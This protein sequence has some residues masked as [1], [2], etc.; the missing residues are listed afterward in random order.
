MSNAETADNII[1]RLW[2]IARMWFADAVDAFGPPAAIARL[3]RF[4][5]RAFARRL[6]ALETLAMKLLLV[7]AAKLPGAAPSRARAPAAPAARAEPAV[8]ATSAD[9]DCPEV[10][11]VRFQLRIPTE[12][13]AAKHGDAPNTGPR[14]RDLGPART[15]ADIM[16]ERARVALHARMSALRAARLVP[17]EARERAKSET[18]AR[19]FEALRRALIDPIP[20]ARRLK[21]KLAALRGRAYDAAMRIAKRRPP[22]GQLNPLVFA[23]AE[24]ESCCV[25]PAAIP[26]SS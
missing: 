5:R 21:R 23:R 14:I 6:K 15:V 25:V 8:P 12:T 7:E 2:S 18:L 17:D 13:D 10:W 4:G 9:P 22:S 24:F 11:R 19:R 16:A 20:R 26:D 3:G 1:A